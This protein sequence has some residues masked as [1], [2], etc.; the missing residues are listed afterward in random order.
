[1]QQVGAETLVVST[2]SVA[3]A[4][5]PA[6]AKYAL[7]YVGTSPVRWRADAS[8]PTS[9][10]GMFAPAGAYIDWTEGYGSPGGFRDMLASVE[11]IR[12]VTASADAAL[13]VAYFA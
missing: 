1:M 4:A 11:F 9:T 10:A 7:M 2:S 3:L 8:D 13:E 5:L 6:A 12:D